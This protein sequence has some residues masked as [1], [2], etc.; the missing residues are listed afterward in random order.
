MDLEQKMVQKE[1]VEFK[2]NDDYTAKFVIDKKFLN[3]KVTSLIAEYMLCMS[4]MTENN[5]IPMDYL[6]DVLFVKYFVKQLDKKGKKEVE[7]DTIPTGNTIEENFNKLVATASAMTN[8]ENVDGTNFLEFIASKFLENEIE[9]NKVKQK[10]EIFS[11]N[12]DSKKEQIND[13]VSEF[14]ERNSLVEK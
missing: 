6:V 8:I 12:I 9:M 7:I 4:H 14:V 13:M 1:V 3:N 10:I 5:I 11:K 2:M